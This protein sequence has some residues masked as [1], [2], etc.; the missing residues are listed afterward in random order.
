[1]WQIVL[2][3]HITP[4][5]RYWTTK[6]AVMM[7]SLVCGFKLRRPDEFLF[8]ADDDADEVDK[9]ECKDFKR[10]RLLPAE[11]PLF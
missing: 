3:T 5:G 9:V 1:M 8:A 7:V 6:V 2:T 11:Y 10:R 4:Y